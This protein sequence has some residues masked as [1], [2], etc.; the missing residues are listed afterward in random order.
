MKTV[1]L[2]LMTFNCRDCILS[3][4]QSIEMQDYPEIEVVISDGGSSDGTVEIIQKFA[5][6]SRYRFDVVSEKDGGLY[7]A[8]NK[9]V[10]RATGD[11]LMVMNDQLLF[12]DAV[13]RLV[14][15]IE[16]ECADGSHADLIYATDTDVIR[17]WHMGKGS[18]YTGW[19][20]GHPTLLLKREV[21]EQYGSYN[22]SYKSAADYEFMIRILKD[23]TVKL[24][25]VPG[26][27]VRMYYGGTSTVSIKSYLRSLSEGHKALTENGIHGAFLIDILR[28]GRVLIQF[29]TTGRVQKKW[30]Q[31]HRRPVC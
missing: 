31:R 15:A 30:Q 25:Y 4:L 12:K 14:E 6:K 23:K 11:Y 26:I 3:T 16:R 21:Y 18:I 17:L 20:P 19:M 29:R 22:I 24:A 5:E 7:D 28:T 2:L 13:R 9:D 27:L 1:S 10:Q 8:L